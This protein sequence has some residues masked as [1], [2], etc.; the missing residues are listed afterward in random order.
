MDKQSRAV[1]PHYGL[2]ILTVVRWNV[3]KFN[4]LS[5]AKCRG[6]A[7]ANEELPNQRREGL[8]RL[9]RGPTLDPVAVFMPRA[10]PAVKPFTDVVMVRDV[11]KR[12]YEKL[13]QQERSGIGGQMLLASPG[14][15]M[16]TFSNYVLKRSEPATT[17]ASHKLRRM[18]SGSRLV[19]CQLTL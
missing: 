11:H 12:L 18:P 1:T 7:Q 10:G 6:G 14:V 9:V 8:D 4:G 5:S 13:V 19:E 15:G 17:P 16:R 3:N 2:H